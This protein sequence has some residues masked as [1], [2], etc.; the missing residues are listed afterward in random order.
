MNIS[1]PIISACLV[2]HNED[3]L[4]RRCLESITSVVD[5]IIL[6]HDGECRDDSLRIAKEYHATIFQQPFVGEAEHHRPF[7]YEQAMGEWILQID[8]DEYLPENAKE[9]ITDLLHQSP[10]DGYHFSWPYPDG[11]GGYIQH[12]PFS[13]TYK[14]CLF[15]KDRMFMIG[16]SHEYPR[17]FGTVKQ[18]DDIQLFHQPL[19]DNYSMSVVRKKWKP[20]AKL[21]AKQIR[22]IEEASYFGTAEIRQSPIFSYFDTIRRH[23]ILSG[24]KENLRYVLLYIVRGILWSDMRSLRIAFLELRYLWMV[25]YYLLH[26]E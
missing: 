23:P 6:V 26:H 17:T 19:Y 4:L 12:G 11:K 5:E 18:T 22:H 3:A 9:T 20:W 1:R 21:Q 13:R 15:R 7:S 14:A 24:L 10:A 8:A 25:R 16:I 2:I